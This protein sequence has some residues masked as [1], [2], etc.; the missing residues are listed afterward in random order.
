MNITRNDK[1]LILGKTKEFI[2]KAEFTGK[3][4]T[5]KEAIE[6]LKINFQDC[7]LT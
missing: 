5:K 6:A 1:G 7:D 4:R 2:I 3:I